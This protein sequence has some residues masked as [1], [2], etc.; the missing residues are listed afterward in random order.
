MA[1]PWRV[2]IAGRLVGEQDAGP[3]A[4]ARASATRCC[5]PPDSWAG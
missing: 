1:P 2:E 3:V 5:S 4:E